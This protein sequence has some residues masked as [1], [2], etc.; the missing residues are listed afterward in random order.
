MSPAI[1][2]SIDPKVI[3]EQLKR[4][5]ESPQFSDTTRTKRFLS[6]LVGEALAGRADDLKGYALGVD[7][8]DKPDDFD[9]GIDTIVRVQANKLR[10][11]LDLYYSQ[12]G[13]EDPV[14][15]HI[16]KGS[17]AP[18]FEIAFDPATSDASTGPRTTRERRTSLAVMPFDNLSGDKDQEYLASGLTEE[19]IAAIARFR[20]V[21]VLSRHV[22]YRF[23]DRARDPRDVGQELGVRYLVEGSIRHWDGNLRV[24]AQLVDAE[25]GEHIFA[26][27]YDRDLSAESLFAVQE[28]VAARIATEIADPHGVIHRTGRAQ[29][30]AETNAF[31]AY[32]CRLLATEYWRH[33]TQEQHARVRDLLERAVQIDPDYAGAWGMLAIVYGDEVRGGF[34]VR[35]DPPPL[36]RALEAAEKSVRR[37]PL[38]ATGQHALFL[39][40]FHLG[41]FDGYRDAAQKALK[42]NPNYADMLA[43]MAVCEALCGDIEQGFALNVR[44]IELCPNPPG[45]YHAGTCLLHFQSGDYAAALASAHQIGRGMW[46]GSEMLILMCLG[47]FD[48]HTDTAK[49][50]D[51][52]ARFHQKVENP[53]EYLE[54]M[55]QVWQVPDDMAHRIRT[56]L[57]AVGAL[58]PRTASR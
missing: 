47:Q 11:R 44:A 9:P 55:L 35:Q 13:R 41:M 7:V 52:V 1:T 57:N 36:A 19:L 48:Q 49:T 43:D 14:R 33:P 12:E 4:V 37:D 2:T 16:P 56:G 8:F 10:T 46:N 39:T 25:T 27:T 20:E 30:K 51:V 5:L 53:A 54:A 23:N 45:W 21:S 17:Y 38:N 26:E 42:A 58:S 31:D 24:V 15:I 40:R 32:Q 18:V 50:K 28:D 29:R 22:T 34:N 3:D 6:H